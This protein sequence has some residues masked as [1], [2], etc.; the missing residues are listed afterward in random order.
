[1]SVTIYWRPLRKQ[2]HF[3]GGTSKELDVL[4]A[5]FGDSLRLGLGAVE[6]LRGMARATGSQ[7]YNEV[8]DAIDKSGPIDIWGE[9]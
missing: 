4:K 1:M 9:H 3:A 7:F 5:Q 6:V 8:A 2:Q